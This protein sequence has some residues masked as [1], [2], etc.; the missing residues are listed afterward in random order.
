[1]SYFQPAFNAVLQ[2]LS[3]NDLAVATGFSQTT[4]SLYK[5]GDR[6]PSRESFDTLVAALP[7]LA[8]LW[9]LTKAYILDATPREFLER[10]RDTLNNTPVKAGTLNEPQPEF[11]DKP[12][13]SALK[14]I[15]FLAEGDETLR[16]AVITLARRL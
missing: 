13:E 16:A 6:V 10:V 2:S 9:N 5:T 3:A 15:Q 11:T 7:F 1:M 12:L 4:I 14:Q 8:D